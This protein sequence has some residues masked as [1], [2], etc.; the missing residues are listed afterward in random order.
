MDKQS[1]LEKIL[2]YI[3]GEENV[4][5]SEM[6]DT[7]LVIILKDRNLV[8]LADL[9]QMKELEEVELLRNRL[10]IKVQ[11][12]KQE[13]KTM[14]N[15][16]NKT[17][18]AKAIIEQVGGKE[19]IRSLRHCYTRLRFSL[20][21]Q[22][23]ANTSALE[24]TEGVIS[25][26]TNSEE[27]MVVIGNDVAIVYNAVCNEAGL[28]PGEVV[29]ENL[30]DEGKKGN[31]FSRV[32]SVIMASMQAIVNLICACGLIKGF[33]TLISMTGFVPPESGLYILMNGMG[34]AIFFFLPIALGYNLAKN[35]HGSPFLGFLI[36][37]ILCYPTLNGVDLDFFGY[38]VNATYTG[39]F[40]PVAFIVA[41]AV[42]IERYL[43]QHLPMMIKGFLTPAIV[44]LITIP[45]GFLIIGP[46]ANVLG[47]GINDGI[48]AL[49]GFNPIICG[50]VFGAIWQILIVFGIHGVPSTFMFMNLAAGNT[51]QLL[52]MCIF[53]NFAQSAVV[54]AMYMKTKS[55]KLKS[56]ALPAFISGMFGITEP[57][58][59]GVTLPRMKMFVVSCIAAAVGC[60]MVA[61]L[62]VTGY[63]FTGTGFF[64]IL[65]MLDPVNPQILPVLIV[66]ATHFICG[67]VLTFVT[68]KDEGKDLEDAKNLN[69]QE[70]PEADIATQN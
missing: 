16:K 51:D 64:A 30:D 60:A 40:L 55:P 59:Y 11:T 65:G 34:D 14:K 53:V 4:S 42:P 35:L 6:M 48:T 29:E 28:K 31:I 43:N 58:I 45:L 22:S 26:V 25:V 68:Y 24:E 49:L 50:L 39:T 52:A 69:K 63:A 10:K 61:V 5:R 2:P 12:D 37:A 27:Y 66:I 54:L 36:G 46:V 13:E 23:K 67:F 7:T 17:E 19:N 41:L 15:N 3:G 9:Q 70:A 33:L 18:L 57:A 20:K 8:S 1:M 56:V 32:L 47:V 38:V 44:L 21:D 62:G